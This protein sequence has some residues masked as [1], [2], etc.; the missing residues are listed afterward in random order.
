MTTQTT[1]SPPQAS[2][3][4]FTPPRKQDARDIERLVGEFVD[5]W[6]HH[7]PARMAALWSDDGDLIT[8]W[9]H[10]ARSRW[11]V[12]QVFTDEHEGPMKSCRHEMDVSDVRWVTT[13][14]AIVDA[15]CN[16]TGMRNAAGQEQPLFQPHVTFVIGR[17][18]PDL[19]VLAARPYAFMPNPAA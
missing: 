4:T 11:S 10:H 8:P 2:S 18:G 3:G 16:L 17:K 1:V 14:V 19:K 7:D 6:N 5:A 13:D 15:T 12:Q 9:G